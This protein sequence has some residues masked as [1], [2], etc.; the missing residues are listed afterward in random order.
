M[1]RCVEEK[2]RVLRTTI[3]HIHVEMRQSTI[4]QPRKNITKRYFFVPARRAL[5]WLAE[6]RFFMDYLDDSI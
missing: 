2:R 5:F 6:K 4:P 3:T 1:D